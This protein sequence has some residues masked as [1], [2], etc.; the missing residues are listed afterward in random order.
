LRSAIVWLNEIE[1]T[2][3]IARTIPH[4]RTGFHPAATR[5]I[6]G[7]SRDPVVAQEVR[8]EK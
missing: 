2:K 8:R 3:S 6:P 4:V 1:I 7:W 5:S